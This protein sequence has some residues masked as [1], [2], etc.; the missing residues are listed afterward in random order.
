MFF[1]F[2]GCSSSN[3]VPQ[4][5]VMGTPSIVGD[6]NDS[7]DWYSDMSNDILEVNIT[8]QK[9][10]A[11]LCPPWDDLSALQ[12]P[13]T[14]EDVYHDTDPNDNYEPEVRVAMES[15]DFIVPNELPNATLKQKGKSTRRARQ[16][17]YRV[18]LDKPLLYKGERTYQFNKHPFDHS[19]VRNKLAFDFFIDIPNFTSLKTRFVHMM[20]DENSTGEFVDYGLFTH[21]EKADE[22]FLINHGWG[23]DDRLYKAQNFDFR[24]TD[25]LL[26]DADGEPLDPDAFDARIEI[27][28]GKHHQKFVQ[29]LKDIEAC[30]TDEAFEVVFA[31]YFNRK[32]YIT[33][34]AIN[35][36]MANKDTI[37]QNFFLLNPLYSDKF[38]FLPWDYDGTSRDTD[39]YAKWEL[40]I[41]T[42]WGIPL[43]KKF[44]NIKH[45]RDELDA[46]VTT[47]REKYITPEKIQS[48]LDDYNKTIEKYI[49][50]LPDS[51]ELSYHRW[52]D[53]FNSLKDR[54]D[55]NIKN[56]ESQ[57]GH[58]MPFWQEVISYKDNN[59]SLSWGRSV[60]FEGDEIVY[61]LKISTDYNMSKIDK[62][63]ISEESLPDIPT[64]DK[65][66]IYYNKVIHLEPGQY[67]MQ[68]I[69]REKYNPEH[70]A[71]GFEK[72][73]EVDDVKYFGVLPFTINE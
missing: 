32:N 8:V 64:I 68:V 65:T 54:F 72:D 52:L 38:Y 20:V 25:A 18:K 12:R 7:V 66:N 27:E 44:L 46:M 14:M 2:V 43:H 51:G 47:L 40:G 39:K 69:A 63:I 33:W 3:S 13:C 9:P 48:R 10:N 29:M 17:S 59:L 45:N 23:E 4:F 56:Y 26:L 34:M 16:K 67:Y 28:N 60:D 41:G 62:V 71:I 6:I 24:M 50:Q 55:V 15:D 49:K 1:L 73:I 11:S 30:R 5:G 42:W 36:V 57:K 19:R 22:T 35:I 53:E 21:I 70:Y 58:P 31:K 61:D 37:S